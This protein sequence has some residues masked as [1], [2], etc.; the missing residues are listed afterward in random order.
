MNGLPLGVLHG[1]I[2]CPVR[3]P[4]ESTMYPTRPKDVCGYRRADLE[5]MSPATRDCA[6]NPVWRLRP[7]EICYFRLAWQYLQR[8]DPRGRRYQTCANA[9]GFCGPVEIHHI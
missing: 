4:R 7:T 5:P 2:R 8:E 3:R 1:D 9:G 6:K